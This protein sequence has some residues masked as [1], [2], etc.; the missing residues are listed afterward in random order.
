MRLNRTSSMLMAALL[1]AG[2]ITVVS[3]SPLY[4][5]RFIPESPWNF[6]LQPWPKYW[7]NF[8]VMVNVLAYIPL[9]LLIARAMNYRQRHRLSGLLHGIVAAFIAGALL[10]VLLEGLQTYLPSRRPSILDVTANTAGAVFGALLTSVYALGKNRLSV[11]EAR[12][13]EIGGLML[14]GLWLL[15]QAAPQQI[16]LA[17]GDVI[18]QTEWRPALAWFN[19]P[20]ES[21]AELNA[22]VF[23]AQRILAEALC[24]TSAITSCAL[25]CHLS[26]L[27]SPRWFARYRPHHWIP[28]L[29]SV[30]VITVAVRIAWILLLLKPQ[31]LSIW[32]NAGTQA[33]VV[34]A[35]LSAYG[36][37]AAKP[38][39]QRIAALCGLTVT[40]L[41]AN[42]LPENGYA[43]ETFI[44]W[45]KGKWLNLQ[46][47]ANFAASVWPF[48][49]L[50]WLG[51]VTLRGSNFALS[52][53]RR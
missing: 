53:K 48:A 49:A 30:T 17:L 52:H 33:G 1:Y 16:W 8:D 50:A 4:D 23:A 6:L 38:S 41:L 18:I 20:P 32:F 15:A 40:L 45:S 24:V 10:S 13:L 37:A 5:W 44:A 14:F 25:I 43:A 36:L 2:G 12:P 34:L 28:T 27:E 26:M 46:V 29:V 22:E 9:G 11:S 51:V 31:A 42:S 39:Q 35:L 19:T 21:L 7:T 3:L 47:L